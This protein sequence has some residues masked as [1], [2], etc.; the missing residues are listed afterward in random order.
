VWTA[1]DVYTFAVSIPPS[2]AKDDVNCEG[3][4]AFMH[5]GGWYSRG[6]PMWYSRAPAQSKGRGGI[7]EEEGVQGKC[8]VQARQ[9]YLPKYQHLSGVS[10]SNAS[11]HHSLLEH[12]AHSRLRCVLCVLCAQAR[13]TW[14][15]AAAAA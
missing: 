8:Q 4:R 2:E 13:C 14:S 3:A 15:T 1:H 12:L 6:V 5:G 11:T 7:M 9:P 10:V